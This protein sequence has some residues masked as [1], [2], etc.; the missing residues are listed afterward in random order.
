MRARLA[1][2]Q[3]AYVDG[4]GKPDCGRV[5]VPIGLGTHAW[6]W[7][8]VVRIRVRARA[9]VHACTCCACM[10]C[11]AQLAQLQLQLHAR[12]QADRYPWLALHVREFFK[13]QGCSHRSHHRCIAC[14]HV[15][16]RA[17]MVKMPR[18]HGHGD[19]KPDCGRVLVPIGRRLHAQQWVWGRRPVMH[20]HVHDMST[21]ACI[22]RT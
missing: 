6:G 8:P 9:R 16:L 3:N 2:H 7:G 17:T 5:L 4:D 12:M 19:G 22:F 13:S 21:C 18:C 10:H 11:I 14:V 15:W 1:R 20:P